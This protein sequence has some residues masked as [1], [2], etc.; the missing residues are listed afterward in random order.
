MNVLRNTAAFVALGLA[1]TMPAGAG[2]KTHQVSAGESVSSIAKQ[3]Y[4]SYEPAPLVLQFNS[5]TSPVIRAGETLRVP[6]CDVHRVKAGD[7]WSALSERY[8]GRPSAYRGIALLNGLAAGQPLQIGQTLVMPVSIP[9]RLARGDTLRSVAEHYYG[10]PAL[11]KAL[12]AFNEI[13]DPRRLTV[14]QAIDVPLVT[15]RLQNK[16]AATRT[17]ERPVPK[18]SRP[19]AKKTAPPE[20]K[21]VPRP[22]QAAPEPKPTVKEA[23]PVPVKEPAPKFL[24]EIEEAR[25]DFYRG[26]FDRARTHV[27]LLRTLVD[28]EGTDTDRVELLRLQAFVYVAFDLPE[29][30]CDAYRSLVQL[31]PSMRLNPQLV[32][33]KIRG[34]L[35]ACQDG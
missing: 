22:V 31:S 25:Q 10:E 35:A 23:V 27:E 8:V 29:Q 7:T 18:P 6:Y 14:G 24:S 3:Y 1:A 12:Q 19:V 2:V 32:S 15:L 13:E 20:S 34:T 9:Y 4:G 17:V 5:K 33:P 28:A 21:A 16:T 11:A 26:E 30:A